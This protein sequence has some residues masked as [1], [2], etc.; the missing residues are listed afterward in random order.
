[1]VQTDSLDKYEKL[2]HTIKS[3]NPCL[4]TSQNISDMAQAMHEGCDDLVTAGYYNQT[5]MMVILESFLLVEGSPFYCQELLSLHPKVHSMIIAN[6]YKLHNEQQDAMIAAGV[7]FDDICHLAEDLYHT[8]LQKGCWHPAVPNKD[9]KLP[10]HV[11]ANLSQTQ[12]FTLQQQHPLPKNCHAD[13]SH[14]G[15]NSGQNHHDSNSKPSGGLG[16]H[17]GNGCC[18][19]RNSNS[20]PSWRR[21]APTDPNETTH[22]VDGTMYFWCGKCNHWTTMHTTDQHVGRHSPENLPNTANLGIAD[23]L[24]WVAHLNVSDSCCV[25]SIPAVTPSPNPDLVSHVPDNFWD[26]FGSSISE[27][28]DDVLSDLAAERDTFP[29]PDSSFLSVDLDAD[30]PLP[31][32]AAHTK[33][34]DAMDIDPQEPAPSPTTKPPASEKNE[35]DPVKVLTETCSQTRAARLPKHPRPISA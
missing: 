11:F 8:G 34:A 28:D 19:S 3:H 24:A 7:S 20:K 2:K 30:A 32:W 1:M 14:N 35:D 25:T 23:P 21:I 13:S 18:H 33:V 15:G 4:Y 31:E 6:C 12:A 29:P 22:V 27:D 16:G 17:G 5:L 26:S 10:P 9:S